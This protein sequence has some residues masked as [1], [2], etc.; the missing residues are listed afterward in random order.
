MKKVLMILF[1]SALALTAN[2]KGKKGTK[3]KVVSVSATEI[4][5]TVGKKDNKEDKTFKISESTVI[6]KGEEVIKADAIVA[7][8]NVQ[9][10]AD[11]EGNATE[12]TVKEKKKKKKKDE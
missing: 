6:K 9:I 8:N 11:A 3:G 4:V 12:I 2:A 10:K 1:M 7:K 5:V